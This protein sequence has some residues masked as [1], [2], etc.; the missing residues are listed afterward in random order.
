MAAGIP[1]VST[2][3][4]DLRCRTQSAELQI[5][6]LPAATTTDRNRV[7]MLKP[8]GCDPVETASARNSGRRVGPYQRR[9]VSRLITTSPR[10]H[11]GTARAR[12]P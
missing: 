12:E 7:P 1:L 8:H 4:R 10:A 11:A 2:T 6:A 5:L 9:W 3:T